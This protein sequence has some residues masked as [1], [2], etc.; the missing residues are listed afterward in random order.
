[1]LA[2]AHDLR[3]PVLDYEELV[4]EAAL[5]DEPLAGLDVDLVC[6]PGY[7]GALVGGEPFE[8]RDSCEMLGV[9]GFTPSIGVPSILLWSS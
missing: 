3:R 9:H 6:L 4:A 1:M 8:E 7:L 5:A 2:A